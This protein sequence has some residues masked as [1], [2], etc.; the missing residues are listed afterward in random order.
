MPS[1]KNNFL[2]LVFVSNCFAMSR[3]SQQLLIGESDH[4][5]QR[6]NL[7]VHLNASTSNDNLALRP[8]LISTIDYLQCSE[9]LRTVN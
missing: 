9:I 4:Y 5:A 6:V 8:D 2:E 1:R 7:N 3:V